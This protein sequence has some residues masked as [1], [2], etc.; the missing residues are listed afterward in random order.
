MICT[1]R[2]R[3]RG[4]GG[5]DAEEVLEEAPLTAGEHLNNGGAPFSSLGEGG[6]G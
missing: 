4:G 5:G 1:F 2:K 3:T 6:R